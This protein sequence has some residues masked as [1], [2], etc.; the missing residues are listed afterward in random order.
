MGK[1]NDLCKPVRFGK[2]MT[3]SAKNEKS[4][5]CWKQYHA[6]SGGGI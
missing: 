4:P 6:V 1:W 2:Q 3:G 5:E